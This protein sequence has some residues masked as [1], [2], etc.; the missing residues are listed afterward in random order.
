MTPSSNPPA[1]RW[2]GSTF[3]GSLGSPARHNSFRRPRNNR[4]RRAPAA[5]VRPPGAEAAT[6]RYTRAASLPRGKSAEESWLSRLRQRA[7]PGPVGP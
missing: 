5:V 6:P 4:G 2:R 7:K 3:P 1:A